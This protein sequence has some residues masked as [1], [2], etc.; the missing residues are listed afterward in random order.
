MAS[1]LNQSCLCNEASIK[2]TRMGS[3]SFWIGEYV[4]MWGEWTQGGHGGSAP[5]PHPLFNASFS[6]D[7]SWV[8]SFINS[9]SESC[10][11]MSD[12][13]WPHGLYSPWNSSGQNTGLGSLSLLQ[14]IFPTQGSNLG[15]L[16]C[17]RILY[18]LRHKESPISS[19]IVCKMALWMLWAALAN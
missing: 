17:R 3:E 19:D 8:T 12:S 4:Q 7:C 15:L 2:T 6:Y 1:E 10:S 11:V 18:Q 9:A 13:L 14:G 5:L 16:Q